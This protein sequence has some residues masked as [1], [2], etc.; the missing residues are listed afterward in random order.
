V[1]LDSHGCEFFSTDNHPQESP[2]GYIN[3]QVFPLFPRR[4]HRFRMEVWNLKEKPVRGT[5]LVGEFS[6]ANPVPGTYPVWTA[7]PLPAARRSG[8]FTFTLTEFQGRGK[9]FE[10]F[11]RG[12]FG[13]WAA[14]RGGR[15]APQWKLISVRL[16][17]AAGGSHLFE[18]YELISKKDTF[19]LPTGVCWQESAYRVRTE[20]TRFHIPGEAPDTVWTV[21]PIPVTRSGMSQT[22]PLPAGAQ[23]QFIPGTSVGSTWEFV[24]G[25][26]P[27]GEGLRFR[28]RARDERGR[29]LKV[30]IT[31]FSNAN[32]R[33]QSFAFNI[34]SG[35]KQ[36][37]LAVEVF[38]SRTVAW[39]VKPSPN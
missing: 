20:F 3:S 32:M 34:P 29:P 12:L 2:W 26:I 14:H 23:M 13:R 15:P 11:T 10:D 24:G 33:T 25:V 27:A 18:G 7:E 28:V 31:G 8:P 21:P 1:L 35:V 6:I 19:R 17:D 9:G 4:E 5:D 22:V 39:T 38:R 37:N 16:S 36:V 30:G